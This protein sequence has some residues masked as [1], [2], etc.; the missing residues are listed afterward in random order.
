MK[1]LIITD[2]YLPGY[3]AGGP[4]KSIE[5]LCD[6][7]KKVLHV[8]V[9]TSNFDLGEDNPYENILFDK[10][11]NFNSHKIIYLSDVKLVKIKLF[12]NK[13]EPDLI[14]LNSFFSK[15]TQIV[16]LLKKFRIIRTKVILAP[17]GEL[18]MGALSIKPIKKSIYLNLFKFLNIYNKDIFFHATDQ[19]EKKD[20][21]KLFGNKI[22]SIP[23]LIS[24]NDEHALITAKQ[25]NKL[26]IIYLSRISEKKNL[27]YAL[28][29]L[30]TNK[31]DGIIEF[32]IYGPIEDV[33]YWKRCKYLIIQ[34]NQ[35]IQI[36]YKGS[37]KPEQVKNILRKNNVFFLPTK[38]ENF[39]HAIV[40]A[41]QCGVVPIVSD[42][43]PWNDLE[44]YNAG[45][46]LN[47]ENQQHFKDAINKLLVLSE[48]DFQC[49]SINVQKYIKS[50]INNKN[51][52]AQYIKMFETLHIQA[53]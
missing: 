8:T 19:I 29:V 27:L 49:M 15:F 47:L 40:E 24:L 1:L 18:S 23:N 50:K 41:M 51:V 6:N 9:M 42:Q 5:T 52:T 20:I 34:A 3:K 33:C 44:E 35:N 38:N 17:R 16:L 28:E 36:K 14:Y 4:I 46:S 7:I 22:F 37:I 26:K 48:N 21:E 2:H 25:K 10:I 11:L 45:F 31:Y 30:V 39:G 12:I 13:I 53:N 32:D 43:T